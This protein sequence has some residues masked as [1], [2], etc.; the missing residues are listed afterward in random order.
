VSEPATSTLLEELTALDSRHLMQT[1]VRQ[2]AAFV[3]GEGATLFD[4]A[5]EPHL[6]FL[7]GISVCNAGH[8]HPH[9][10]EAI[11]DQSGRLMQA[12]NLYYT[13]PGTHLAARLAR[14]FAQDARVFLCNSG[15]EANEAAIKLVRKHRSEGEIVVLEGAFHGRT[16]GALSATPQPDKQR[17]FAPLVPGFRVVPRD[18]PDR[19]TAAV[20][21]GTAAVMLE[22]I[23]GE[24][25][26]WPIADEV[27]LA[28]R[29]ACDRHGA[30]LVMDEIQTGMGRTGTLWAHEQTPVRPDVMTVAKSLASG[31]PVG[32]V[33]ARGEAAGVLVPGD[34]GSTFGGGPLVAAAALATL[35]VIDDE[36]MLAHVRET[37]AQLRGGL[38]RLQA[39]G[40]LAE[41]RGRGLMLGADLPAKRGGDAPALVHEALG[42]GLVLNAT[43]PDTLRFLPPFVIGPAEVDRVLGFLEAAL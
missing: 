23:Q 38:E 15:T 37:G 29:A 13:E 32:A 3:R 39:A 11:R 26:I 28:A 27:L 34:H 33:L 42:S 16:L 24:T 5:G 7:A 40:L 41:V 18:D 31:L 20:G 19:L 35:D 21:D 25:G 12:S 4:G 2:P 9:V 36:A 14:S 17:P 6:D 22:P 30:L 43:G 1:Y 8:C 10:V